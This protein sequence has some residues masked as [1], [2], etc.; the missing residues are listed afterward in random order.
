[1]R[2][3]L[4]T[5]S[6]R[7]RR[8]Y[9]DWRGQ[10]AHP[11]VARRSGHLYV[12]FDDGPDPSGTPQILDELRRL[13]A[14]ATFYVLGCLVEQSEDLVLR[15]RD[16]GHDV[17]LHG[18]EHRHQARMR[19]E[20]AEADLD[21]ALEVLGGLGIQPTQW[22]LPG[23]GGNWWT[24]ELAASRRLE[25]VGFS[26]DPRDW[27]GD[28]AATMLERVNRDIRPG[29]VLVLHDAPGVGAERRDCSNTVELLE[30]L[31]ALARRRGAE[32]VPVEVP[33]AFH[34]LRMAPPPPADAGVTSEIEI[35]IVNEDDLSER[36][37]RALCDLLAGGISRDKDVYRERGWRRIR[38]EYRAIAR[39]DGEIAGQM[40]MFRLQTTPALR[41]YGS[42]D[43]VVR[44]KSRGKKIGT[45]LG[46]VSAW[47]A[48][49]RGIDLYVS[50]SAA[51]VSTYQDHGFRPAKPFEVW[52]ERDGACHRHPNWHL[53]WFVEPP[54]ERIQLEEGDF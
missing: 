38:P 24:P 32:P 19:R 30:P 8:G 6:R 26:A 20:E 46:R 4:R 52:Y 33:T 25:I 16:E 41:V 34:R 12:T 17:Q 50:D 43:A 2:E 54:A 27:T 5:V 44:P 1:V 31:F 37:L 28:D 51:F 48:Y 22:R 36:D 21:A 13:D 47:E 40:S 9:R 42:G 15:A 18:M 39:E 53:Y 10:G 14:R 7:L 23:G 3:G 29:R 49:E 45:E 11:L 35:E